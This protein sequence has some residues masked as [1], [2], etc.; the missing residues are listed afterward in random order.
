MK[1]WSLMLKGVL[2]I[3]VLM[4]LSSFQVWVVSEMN[5]FTM[6][7]TLG[8]VLVNLAPVIAYGF[9]GILISFGYSVKI[10]LLPWIGLGVL[11]ILGCLSIVLMNDLFL[12]VNYSQLIQ[13]I[14]RVGGLIMG[15]VVGNALTHRIQKA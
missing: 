11:M 10:P 9:I 3:G 15:M 4:S 14:W 7:Y 6:D 1:I 8:L 12:Y 13:E 5:R 2:L